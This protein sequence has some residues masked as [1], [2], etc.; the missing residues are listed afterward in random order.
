[1]VVVMAMACPWEPFAAAVMMSNPCDSSCALWLD[2]FCIPILT[3]LTGEQLGINSFLLHAHRSQCFSDASEL[4]NQV[5][6]YSTCTHW[7]DWII[8]NVHTACFWSVLNSGQSKEEPLYLYYKIWT[9][10]PPSCSLAFCWQEGHLYTNQAFIVF[11]S[12]K[13]V[14]WSLQ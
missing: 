14:W 13:N 1:M 3:T 5:L 2:Q 9:T 8:T 11:F 6:C 7:L 4:Y 12:F 10:L